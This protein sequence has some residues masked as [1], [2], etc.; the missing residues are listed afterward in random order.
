MIKVLEGDTP[1]L[2]IGNSL[3]DFNQVSVSQTQDVLGFIGKIS[4]SPSQL[5]SQ[6]GRKAARKRW[7]LGIGCGGKGEAVIANDWSDSRGE[8]GPRIDGR[9]LADSCVI[10]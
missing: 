2:V 7:G 10:G 9:H 6:F 3:L 1:T 8:N 4:P 5:G